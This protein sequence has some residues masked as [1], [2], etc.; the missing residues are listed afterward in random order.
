MKPPVIVYAD[1]S[2]AVPISKQTSLKTTSTDKLNL[3]LVRASQ[4][5]SAFNIELRHKAGKTNI[6]PDAL[7]RLEVKDPQPL[8]QQEDGILDVL[9]GNVEIYKD[10]VDT[11]QQAPDTVPAVYHATLVEMAEDFKQRIKLGYVNDEQWA[12]IITMLRTQELDPEVE[13]DEHRVPG[14]NF[15]LRNNL[16]YYVPGDGRDR[17][18]IP[19]EL[20]GE[21][22]GEAHNRY[23]QGYQR[24]FEELHP[25]VFIRRMRKKVKDY[26]EHCHH[27]QLNQTRRH[28]PYGSLHPILPTAP[29][30]TITMDF[31]LALPTKFTDKDCLLTITCKYTKKT[32]LIPGLTTYSAADWA[33]LVITA[34]LQHDWGIPAAIISDR[35]RKFMSSF[36]RQVFQRLGTKILAS[37][38]YHPQTDGQSE[39]TNQTVEIGLRFWITEHPDEDWTKA[40]PFLQFALN[41]AISF[42]TGTASNELALGFLPKDTVSALSDLLPE[43]IERLRPIKRAEAEDIIAFSTALS[44]VR[45]D[46]LHKAK[47]FKTG[48]KVFLR[49]HHGYTLPDVTN[50]KL[51]NQRAGPFKVIR[52]IG[53]LA[54]ELELPSTMKIHPVISIA[55]LEP[56]P[57][58]A[59]P[60]NRPPVNDEPPAVE[61]EFPEQDPDQ[62]EVERVADRR[63]VRQRFQY[64][65]KWKGYRPQYNSWHGLQDLTHCMDLVND[66]DRAFPLP[67]GVYHRRRDQPR[68]YLDPSG[69]HLDPS[70]PPPGQPSDPTLSTEQQPIADATASLA[71][72]GAAPTA[73]LPRR[74]GLRARRH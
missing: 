3:R 33:N 28:R 1:H 17:L 4:Y 44:K 65:V 25:S 60:F 68:P 39:R 32:L 73:P 62:F 12:K 37:T 42:A 50:R 21:V 63:K 57:T 52:K 51:S 15:R 40:I 27:C 11:L 56:A 54:Y 48:D 55:Q 70:R 59:D 22:I 26:V 72:D 8:D 47:S 24:V 19:D 41:N 43:D 18:Y 29:Y 67:E 23:H 5:L 66:Y 30:H 71:F 14:I 58:G 45:Y 36:W 38:A 64:L 69:T 2:A 46:S 7:S 13:D 34:L 53:H 31:V 6:V 16:L 35:D 20:A 9:Y 10:N 49:L 74:E 61:M